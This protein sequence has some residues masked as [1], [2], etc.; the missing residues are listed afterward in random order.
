MPATTPTIK[1]RRTSK[2]SC[3]YKEG[4]IKLFFLG[5]VGKKRSEGCIQ[6]PN[7]GMLLKY[8]FVVHIPASSV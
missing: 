4:A 2:L 3:D 8:P 5:Q 1:L 7:Q 6:L